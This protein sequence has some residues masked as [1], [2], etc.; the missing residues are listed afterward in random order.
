MDE[1][2]EKIIPSHLLSLRQIGFGDFTIPVIERYVARHLL[3]H[4]IDKLCSPELAA[5]KGNAFPLYCQLHE[6]GCRQRGKDDTHVPFVGIE[7]LLHAQNARVSELVSIDSWHNLEKVGRH[8]DAAAKLHRAIETW[9]RPHNVLV[10]WFLDALLRNLCA[11]RLEGRQIAFFYPGSMS[12]GPIGRFGGDKDIPGEV[13]HVGTALEK[14]FPLRLPEPFNPLTQR[15]SEH[16]KHVEKA[17]EEYYT[18]REKHLTEIGFTKVKRKRDRSGDPWVHVEWFVRYQVKG[19]TAE[20]IADRIKPRTAGADTIGATGIYHAVSDFSD[21][22][23]LPLRPKK[24][25]RA[26][27]RRANRS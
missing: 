13:F 8:L 15:R 16:W 5:L 12:F 24:T 17:Y 25:V 26:R 3:F 22:V 1:E 6:I 27:N 20:R 10:D 11:W 9:A 18:M 21:L 19:W 14:M 4:F 2:L 23:E 7:Y